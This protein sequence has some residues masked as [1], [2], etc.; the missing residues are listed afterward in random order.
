MERRPRA[1]GHDFMYDLRG[2]L[3][4]SRETAC[5]S[6]DAD[7]VFSIDFRLSL[8]IKG[9]DGSEDI[10]RVMYSMPFGIYLHMHPQ[11]HL[12][13]FLFTTSTNSI[14]ELNN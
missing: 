1:L 2:V 7:E 8:I 12:I 13:I 9:E 5:M 14:K 11:T 3:F 4:R 6:L 10:S